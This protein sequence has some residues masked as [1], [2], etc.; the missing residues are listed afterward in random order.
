MFTVT[1]ERGFLPTKDPLCRLPDDYK[2]LESLLQDMPIV[3]RD[4]T[5]G[6]LGREELGAAI[7][8]GRLPLYDLSSV[9]DLHLLHA[10]FR[11]YTFLASAYLL[12]PCHR[13]FLSTGEYGLGRSRLPKCIAVPLCVVAEKLNVFPFMEYAL[14]YALMNWR[15]K[16]PHIPGFSVGNLELIRCF[17]GSNDE[18]GF[19][20]VHVVMVSHSGGLVYSADRMLASAESDDRLTFNEAI[21]EYYKALQA[22]NEEMETMWKWS[23]STGYN[24]FRTFIMGTKDQPMFPEGVVYEGVVDR[25]TGIDSPAYAFR[26]ESGA[27]DSMI[28]LSDNL[29]QLTER[30]PQNPLTA[31]LKDFRRYRPPLHSNYLQHVEQK[32]KSVGV[33]AYALLD[34]TNSLYYLRCL[35]KI[36]EFR[37]RHW[38][39][40]KEY[41]L[42]QSRHP[43]ATGGSPIVTWLPNQL[44]VVLDAIA[45]CECEDVEGIK[46]SASEQSVKLAAEVERILTTSK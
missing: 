17:E 12:E 22:V 3:K 14:S 31:I 27:N 1:K 36:R 15:F 21:K 24:R 26:G 38:N 7:D 39:F 46:G 8:S 20:L 4:G 42:K 25:E 9:T 40:T 10:L 37:T 16:D 13:R 34:K 41:I 45:E 23:V 2:E 28:P 35:D 6:L 29:F 19:I 33:R 43:R 11:D 44:M 5:T 30:M 18:A 32:A